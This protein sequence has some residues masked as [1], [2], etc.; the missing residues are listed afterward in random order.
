VP[1]YLALDIGTSSTKAVLYQ[2]DGA[3]L[4]TSSASYGVSYPR[5]GWAEQDPADWW[6]AV[7]AVCQDVLRACSHPLV[8]AVSLSGQAP[9]CVPVDRQGKPLREAILWLDRRAAPQADWLHER[10]GLERAEKISGNT[11]DSYYGG[12]K[13]LWFRQTEPDR[14][15]HTWKILQ[16]SGYVTL[17]LTG[18]AVIDHSQ[19]GL[20]SPAYNLRQRSWD[21]EACERMGIE[22]SVL[23]TLHNAWE[24]VGQVTP[25]AAAATHL[26]AGTPVV[27]GGGDYAC[28]CLGAGV[29]R[30]GAAAMMLGTSGNLLVPAPRGTD[31]RLFNTVHVTGEGLSLGGVM[32]GGA[33]RW[34]LDMLGDENP[35]LLAILE[36][37]ALQVPSGAEGLIFLPYLMGER[38]PIWDPYAR[39]VFLGLSSRHRRGHLYRAV[40][41]GVALAYRQMAEIFTDLG[42]PI[43]EVIAINGG[44]RS[45]LWRQ[46]FA[47]I[48]G[49]PVRWR[50]TSGGTGLGA[51]FLAALGMNDQPRFENLQAWLEPTL[52][53]FPNSEPAEVY[54]RHYS[55]FKSL[56]G[57]LKDDFRQLGA[58]AAE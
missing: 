34:F 19:A 24:V 28:A 10:L 54:A 17:Q 52:D 26:P 56:H 6:E 20:C 9:S 41:E 32:A 36:K 58:E 35:D 3:L 1:V 11:L 44:A 48:L 15:R 30:A 4:G 46:I 13:W 2:E 51:A 5:P 7:Q 40:L 55:I 27:C 21:A 43:D 14:Y 42:S 57:R 12:V 45:P 53:T 16:A 22:L 49:I 8:R 25:Q 23:P 47:D 33:V 38:T 29:M 37:E 50:P 18:E 31:L 39:G